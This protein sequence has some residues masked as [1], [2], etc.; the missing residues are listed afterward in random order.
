MLFRS[1]FVKNPNITQVK[2]QYQDKDLELMR[3]G[4]YEVT[5]STSGTAKNLTTK[6]E[7]AAKTG[8]AQ[9]VGIPQDQKKRMK[10]SELEHY[11][12][13]HAWMTAYGPYK[14]PQYA[15]TVLKEHG[16]YGASATG[17]EV[18]K[19]FDKLVELGYIKQ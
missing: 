5:H 16:G 12:R 19:I 17:Y 8:T 18:S 10:E 11:E 4:M 3:K 13:S 2:L 15:V 7:L 14:N 1:H 9:V 6:V